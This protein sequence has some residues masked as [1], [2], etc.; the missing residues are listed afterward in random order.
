MGGTFWA[1]S[2]A[3][4]GL[5][6]PLRVALGVRNKGAFIAYVSV[7][8]L[9]LLISS[10]QVSVQPPVFEKIKE[11]QQRLD[12]LELKHQITTVREAVQTKRAV[13]YVRQ[14]ALM[15]EVAVQDASRFEVEGI[16]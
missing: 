5:F 10:Y 4:N 6:R 2:N 12:G 14:K 16:C 3:F 13:R 11:V 8:L 1:I 7:V 9:G 15:R